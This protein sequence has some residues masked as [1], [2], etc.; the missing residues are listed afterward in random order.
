VNFWRHRGGFW[1]QP[2]D[3]VAQRPRRQL[4]G[5]RSVHLTDEGNE[6]YWS[7]VHIAVEKGM[8]K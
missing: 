2:V 7:S 1:R 6:A 5:V 3:L 4:F 8:K